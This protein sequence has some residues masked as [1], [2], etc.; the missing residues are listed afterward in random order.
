M[1]TSGNLGQSG[2]HPGG[3][4]ESSETE[5]VGEGYEAVWHPAGVPSGYYAPPEVC[6][7]LRPPATICQPSGLNPESFTNT[8]LG[9]P[10]DSQTA[11]QT[12]TAEP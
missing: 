12:Q 2:P 10:S 5:N 9:R 3:M 8:A 11:S 4:P 6:A 1:E 7:A